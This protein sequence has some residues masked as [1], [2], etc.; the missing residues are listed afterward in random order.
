MNNIVHIRY[1]FERSFILGYILIAE[2]VVEIIT[3]KIVS[4]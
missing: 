4:Y 2:K 1:P 3:G